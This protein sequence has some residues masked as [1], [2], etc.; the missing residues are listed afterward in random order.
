MA[1]P[2]ESIPEAFN[3]MSQLARRVSSFFF[4]CNLG[5]LAK[6]A[7]ESW[8]VVLWLLPDSQS[9]LLGSGGRGKRLADNVISV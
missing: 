8:E 2:T 9:L 7:V 6:A 4:Q 3:T 1:E 5:N